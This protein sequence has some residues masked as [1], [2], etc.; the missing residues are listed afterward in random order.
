MGKK[1]EVGE[2]EEKTLMERN[3]AL[4]SELNDVELMLAS[5][6]EDCTEMDDEI[7]GK[8]QLQQEQ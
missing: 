5:M 1:E 2:V 4:V 8:K 7:K 6:K 3:G